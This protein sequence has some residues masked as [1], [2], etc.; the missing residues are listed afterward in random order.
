MVYHD[1]LI[2]LPY[3]GDSL[4]ATPEFTLRK[5]QFACLYGC[6]PLFSFTVGNFPALKE[7]IIDAY[8]KV[9]AIHEKIATLPMTDF[10][11][12][13]EDY[14]LQRSVFGDKYEVIVNFTDKN[15]IYNGETILPNAILF[16]KR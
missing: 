10:E 2:S 4:A 11:I 9:T 6:P 14:G 8:K 3:W 1:C 15:Y 13:T 16:K 7:T 5:I 12:I